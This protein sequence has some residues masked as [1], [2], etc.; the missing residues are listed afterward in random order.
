MAKTKKTVE[1]VKPEVAQEQPSETVERP[2]VPI[3]TKAK[4]VV[5]PE[6]LASGLFQSVALPDGGYVVY[7]PNGQRV[8]GVLND[9][10][11]ADIV[12]AQNLAAHL[13]PKPVR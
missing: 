8:S 5:Y 6:V 1:E 11:A 3:E 4:E 10:E 9:V 12:R 2:E 13:K 7:N